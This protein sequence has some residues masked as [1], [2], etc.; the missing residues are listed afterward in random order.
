M[1]NFIQIDCRS[2]V[3]DMDNTLYD[4][5]DFFRKALEELAIQEDIKF[6]IDLSSKKLLD[7]RLKSKDIFY[8]I[9]LTDKSLNKKD[10]LFLKDKLFDLAV[11][12]DFEISPYNDL[13][14]FLEYLRKLNINK[15]ILTNGV[16]AIQ[17]NKFKS[18]SLD[19]LGP[20]FSASIF[21]VLNF[22]ILKGLPLI[23]I[24]S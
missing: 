8:D 11:N 16:P 12:Y 21:I 10:I 20:S 19:N 17:K 15:Y 22:I 7:L 9:L 4:E 23:P 1:K 5:V 14:P 6:H 24:L 3:F 2:V 18:L 13:L